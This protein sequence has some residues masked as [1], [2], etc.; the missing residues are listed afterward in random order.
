MKQLRDALLKRICVFLSEYGFDNKI[1]GQSF[2][3]RIDG[4]GA[5]IHLNFINHAND[6]DVVVSV[7]IRFDTMENMANVVNK[8]LTEKERKKSDSATIGIELG[9]LS[10]G[11]QK[12]WTIREEDDIPSVAEG[13]S[14]DII[15]IAFPFIGKY[16][17]M[18]AVFEIM[19]RDDSAV[20]SLAPF[21]HRRAMNAVGLA[22]LLKKDD[23]LDTIIAKKIKFLEERNDY[24]LDMFLDFVKTI[25]R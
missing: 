23:M 7:G 21:H 3:K 25:D 16:K 5:R 6:F 22:K 4:G 2:R 11:A 20:W 24:G 15:E 8:L 1:Y 12:R 14:K 17:D 18:N 9:N 19:L 10:I 13:I